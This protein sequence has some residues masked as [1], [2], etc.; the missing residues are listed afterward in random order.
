ME[1]RGGERTSSQNSRMDVSIM[2]VQVFIP[3]MTKGYHIPLIL[4]KLYNIF[5]EIEVLLVTGGWGS[6]YK[7]IASTEVYR[8]SAGEWR[9]VP[10][11]ALPRPMWGIRVVTLN[12]KVLLF[13]D[14][15][16]YYNIYDSNRS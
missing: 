10:G 5:C 1:R 11:G 3:T 2:D 7:L 13:G 12:N 6:G 8:P 15:L 14:K 9:E 16:I 4:V